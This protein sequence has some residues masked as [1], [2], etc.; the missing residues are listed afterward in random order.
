[1]LFKQW[2]NTRRCRDISALNY[3]DRSH[4]HRRVFGISVWA[5]SFPREI[6]QERQKYRNTEQVIDVG[7]TFPS[8]A[9]GE[10]STMHPAGARIEGTAG[11][12]GGSRL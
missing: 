5:S 12:L 2:I 11:P 6:T 3:C 8:V 10:Q 7:A 9:P 1:M 4:P